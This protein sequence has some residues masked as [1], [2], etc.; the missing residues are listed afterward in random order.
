MSAHR[1]GLL[2]DSAIPLL[3]WLHWVK[4]ACFDWVLH[5]CVPGLD[6]SAVAD[7]VLCH[8]GIY[9]PGRNLVNSPTDFGVPCDRRRSFTLWR[10][11]NAAAAPE[12]CPSVEASPL[13]LQ[14]RALADRFRFA[15]ETMQ[16]L[17]YQ[18][19]MAKASVYLV[20]TPEEVHAFYARR[21]AQRKTC[22]P[23]DSSCSAIVDDDVI[24]ACARAHL[25][26]YHLLHESIPMLGT[27]DGPD[28][29]CLLQSPYHVLPKRGGI[30]PPLLRNSVIY[31]L[32][33]RRLVLPDELMLC[34]GL[35]SPLGAKGLPE[36][37]PLLPWDAP[38]GD[39]V[40][41]AEARSMLGNG[42]HVV[43]IAAACL[44]ALAG[45]LSDHPPP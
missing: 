20:A 21:A 17:F 24:P 31:S 30:M 5:E 28:M 15:S 3:V 32:G 2:H 34:M 18:K 12:D 42:M 35:P 40:G 39:I 9:D 26:E 1:W 36:L 4:H 41:E 45:A 25:Q 13:E 14:S 6:T 10:L 7:P 37:E 22:L 38:L 43:Q 8:A 27:E 11:A 44:L 16:H 33:H 19:N 23:A 29:V